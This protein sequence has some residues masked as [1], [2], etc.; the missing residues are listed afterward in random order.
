M[1]SRPQSLRV[2]IQLH[3]LISLVHSCSNCRGLPSR[4]ENSPPA[5]PSPVA[6]AA[7]APLQSILRSDDLLANFFPSFNLLKDSLLTP[8]GVAR[9]PHACLSLAVSTFPV[10]NAPLTSTGLGESAKGYRCSASHCQVAR[11]HPDREVGR[12]CRPVCPQGSEQSL[13]VSDA[14]QIEETFPTCAMGL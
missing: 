1:R 11:I 14:I 4:S 3:S 8:I 10:L 12:L 7:P 2:P 13:S 5:R 9:N 6:F